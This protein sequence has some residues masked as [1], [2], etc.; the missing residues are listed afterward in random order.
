MATVESV[1]RFARDLSGFVFDP[2]LAPIGS[3]RP[4][5]TFV[6]ETRD[7]LCGYVKSRADLIDDLDALLARLGGAN[8]VTGPLHVEGC[9]AGDCIAVSILDIAAAPRTGTGWTAVIPGWGGLAE[10]MER[11][12]QD[13]LVPRTV[14][15][16][17]ADGRARL[18]VDGH[19]V[20]IPVA[21]FVGTVGVA[22]RR[23]RR[24]TLS[25]S[26]EYLGDVDIRSL[27]VGSTVVLRANVD[28]ALLSLGDVHAA[29]GDGE[30][31]GVAIEV[32]ADV[33]LRVDVLPAE[34]AHYGSLPVL[35]TADRIGVIAGLGGMPLTACVRA[36]YADLVRR[37]QRERGWSR[38]GA[39]VLLGQAGRIEVGNMMGAF[40]SCLVSV[41]RRCLDS[42]QA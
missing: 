20:T 23:E 28:G 39:C 16:P 30:I 11:S 12:I 14:I 37:L 34:R 7:S 22:P 19:R 9:R 29:Q 36:A 1:Q 6:V 3:V 38:E 42:A 27:G 24:V 21:P 4:G 15:C 17:I 31:T 18:D 8:P 40:Q 13:P 10:D 26:P 32:E 33:T 41:D 2:G 25:Q 35:E 5:E